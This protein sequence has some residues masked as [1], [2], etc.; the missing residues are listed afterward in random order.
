MGGSKG[1]AE[2]KEDEG[3]GKESAENKIR[4]NLRKPTAGGKDG[5]D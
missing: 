5:T 1:G 4:G 2:V 3:V